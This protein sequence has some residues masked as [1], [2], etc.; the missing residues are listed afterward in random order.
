MTLQCPIY[1]NDENFQG[2]ENTKILGKAA[3]YY[4][5]NLL[6]SYFFV[7]SFISFEIVFMDYENE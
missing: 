2:A 1:F 3:L 5:N 4:G 7:F 6:N